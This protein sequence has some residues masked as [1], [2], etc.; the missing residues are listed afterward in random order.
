VLYPFLRPAL[1]DDAVL[2]SLAVLFGASP[3]FT[4]SLDRVGWFGDEVVWLGPRDEAPFRGLTDLVCASFPTCA[5]Y[6]GQHA[7]VIPHL[8]IGHLGGPVALRAAGQ[9]VRPALP[10]GAAATHVT[11]MTGPRPGTRGASPGRWRMTAAF[12]LAGADGGR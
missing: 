3:V 2:T 1:I 8:T 4:F 11:L 6:G 10:I 12:P 5:P 9:E 7:D